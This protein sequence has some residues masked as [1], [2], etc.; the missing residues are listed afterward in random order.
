MEGHAG[1]LKEQGTGEC[2][3]RA[4]RVR[5]ACCARCAALCPPQALLNI[6]S[7]PVNSTVPI[8]A[9]S[10]KKVGQERG[11]LKK[12]ILE[13]SCPAADTAALQHGRLPPGLSIQ[14]ISKYI[15]SK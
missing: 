7:N 2:F 5:R 9:E 11:H 6:I 8:A 14:I 1:E 13:K 10:L 15:L 3:P 12:I 4:Q